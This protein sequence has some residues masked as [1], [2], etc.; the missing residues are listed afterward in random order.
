LITKRVIVEA[1][2]TCQSS[3]DQELGA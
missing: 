2:E 3:F 1:S